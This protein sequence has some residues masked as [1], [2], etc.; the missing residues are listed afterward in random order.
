[1]DERSW[2]LLLRGLEIEKEKQVSMKEAELQKLIF[3]I[4]RNLHNVIL[5]LYRNRYFI[6]K[7]RLMSDE[8]KD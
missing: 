4:L 5:T 7:K 3:S 1:M 8:T 2:S 6:K